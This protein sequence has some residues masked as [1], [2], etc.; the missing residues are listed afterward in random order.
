MHDLD[1]YLGLDGKASIFNKYN[2]PGTIILR[3]TVTFMI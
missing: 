3:Q 2:L 1:V